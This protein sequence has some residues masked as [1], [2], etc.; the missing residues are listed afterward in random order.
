MSGF[1]SVTVASR[2]YKMS[3]EQGQESR[4]D[5][6]ADIFNSYIDQIKEMGGN[7]MDRDQMIVMAGILMA[8]EHLTLRQQKDGEGETLERYHSRLAERIEGLLAQV[9]A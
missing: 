5:K 4:L 7:G 9:T 6:V 2:E 1:K 3:V 8:D